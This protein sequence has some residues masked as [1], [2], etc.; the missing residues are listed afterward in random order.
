MSFS[1]AAAKSLHCRQG[2]QRRAAA[3]AASDRRRADRR[4]HGTQGSPAIHVARVTSMP[5]LRN[6]IRNGS[7]R[8]PDNGQ[9]VRQCLSVGHS[10]SLEAGSENEQIGFVVECSKTFG[11]Y[12]AKR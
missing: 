12:R 2:G 3:H 1:N 8:C 4:N 6:G 5:I 7:G 11:R 10:I 9:A